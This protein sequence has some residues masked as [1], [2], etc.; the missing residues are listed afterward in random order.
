[1]EG[2]EGGD[3]EVCNGTDLSPEPLDLSADN[4]AI[5]FPHLMSAI[6]NVS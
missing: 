3:G 4:G 5:D 1:M 2:K 6:R